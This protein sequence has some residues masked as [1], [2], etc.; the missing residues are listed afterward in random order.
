MHDVYIVTKRPSREDFDRADIWCEYKNPEE[1]DE[2]E[3]WGVPRQR[4]VEALVG[5]TEQSNSNPFYS[6]PND[7][8]FAPR[9]F[10][11]V[12]VVAFNSFLHIWEPGCV[13][14]VDGRITAL[15]VFR[16]MGVEI[17]LYKTPAS[18]EE[19]FE[20]LRDYLGAPPNAEVYIR[21]QPRHLGVGVEVPT[22]L[23]I[24]FEVNRTSQPKHGEDQR[25]NDEETR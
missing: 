24:P 2:L 8:E 11:F 6:I 7:C 18:L 25:A 22:C 20:A 4:S 9:E 3:K 14:V 12:G 23:E 1:L 10:L 16:D 17:D 13:A 19:N 21:L 15:T 5:A